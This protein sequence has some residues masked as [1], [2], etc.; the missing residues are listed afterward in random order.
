MCTTQISWFLCWNIIQ[1]VTGVEVII[2]NFI[3]DVCKTLPRDRRSKI[4]GNI[5]RIEGIKFSIMTSTRQSLFVPQNQT[6]LQVSKKTITKKLRR[7]QCCPDNSVRATVRGRQC[8][9]VNV[10]WRDLDPSHA[11][12]LRWDITI[13][14]GSPCRVINAR[15]SSPDTVNIVLAQ[16]DPWL[17]SANHLKIDPSVYTV[18]LYWAYVASSWIR[19][20][21]HFKIKCCCQTLFQI[22][23]KHFQRFHKH[24]EDGTRV[25]IWGPKI[26]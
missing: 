21:M 13:L 18:M 22:F 12:I 20:R 2:E 7:F 3:P 10:T 15:N 24:A 9:F 16:L 11:G 4:E 19:I 26:T 8:V 1:N 23:A 5:L 17:V 6:I 25:G 14:F